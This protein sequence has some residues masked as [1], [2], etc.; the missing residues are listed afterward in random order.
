MENCESN[1]SYPLLTPLLKAFRDSLR[2]RRVRSEEKRAKA[3]EKLLT[4][5]HLAYEALRCNG[6]FMSMAEVMG[7]TDQSPA[8]VSVALDGLYA[9]DQILKKFSRGDRAIIIARDEVAIPQIGYSAAL[10]ELLIGAGFTKED[11]FNVRVAYKAKPRDD[12]ENATTIP[13][14]PADSIGQSM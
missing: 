9:R 8:E 14:V 7:V 12:G 5:Q 1:K 3:K 4:D 10:Q 2:Q 13:S 6:G 11:F